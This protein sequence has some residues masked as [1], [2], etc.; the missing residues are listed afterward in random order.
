MK[1]GFRAGQIRFKR[2]EWEKITSD[3]NVLDMISGVKIDLTEEPLQGK[4]HESK[5][6]K[7]ETLQIEKEISELAKKGV[8]VTCDKKEGDFISPIFTRP[9]KDGKLRLILNL[10]KLNKSVEYHHFKMET[11]RQ[12]LA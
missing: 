9:K 2:E 4:G 10:K 6:S 11:L 5:F 3:K 1:H 7:E 12:A 8:I